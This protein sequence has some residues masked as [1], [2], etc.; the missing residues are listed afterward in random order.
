[1][2]VVLL[3]VALSVAVLDGTLAAIIAGVLLCAFLGLAFVLLYA[4][5]WA[6]TEQGVG[7]DTG[8]VSFV[9]KPKWWIRRRTMRVPWHEVVWISDGDGADDPS[10][11]P[12]TVSLY[13]HRTPPKEQAPTWL[14]HVAEGADDPELPAF[15][16]L[17]RVH[18]TLDQDEIK[19][20]VAAFRGHRPHL[21]GQGSPT[22][23]P[24][25]GGPANG[26]GAHPAPGAPGVPGQAPKNAPGTATV[27]Y[28]GS[29]TFDWVLRTVLSVTYFLMATGLGIYLGLDAAA[30][31]G[32]LV[33]PLVFLPLL[34]MAAGAFVMVQVSSA[35]RAL[36]PQGVHVDAYGISIYRNP[37]WWF[38]GERAHVGWQDVHHFDSRTVGSRRHAVLEISVHLHRTTREMRLPPWARLVMAGETKWRFTAPHHPVLLL[39]LRGGRKAE[40]LLK[41][42][43]M[44]RPDL[45]VERLEKQHAREKDARAHHHAQQARRQQGP[46]RQ[47]PGQQG[48]PGAQNR[49]WA[50]PAHAPT[51]WMNLRHETLRAWLMGAVPLA[52]LWCAWAYNLLEFTLS[53]SG[54][55]LGYVIGLGLAG[56]VFSIVSIRIMPNRLAH[57]GIS[58][59]GYG[60]TLVQGPFLWS[61]GSTAHLP[62]GQILLVREDTPRIAGSN[63]GR[64]RLSA[65][66]H[67][68][69][70]LTSVPHWCELEQREIGEPPATA[71]QPLTRVRLD[72]REPLQK[73]VT[74][75]VRAIRPDLIDNR[76]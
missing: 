76:T 61:S 27:D 60:I 20:L 49:P 66:M 74:E 35:P 47:G 7:V 65:F 58:V 71:H 13:L 53:G 2:A 72:I 75:A 54:E 38:N 1:M 28:G 68:P 18:V 37:K 29:Q 36:T 46:G 22:H 56:T 8:G 15:S 67:H 6:Y 11:V 57:Q 26:P 40:D 17:P 31:D 50:D 9:Q 24:G 25:P 45:S 64:H 63:A 41:I 34:I 4:L 30:S 62:W 14:G 44:A 70:L 52:F 69:D 48:F 3:L 43:R 55:A 10:L 39:R 42:L 23:I 16:P 21:V 32:G 33:L 59:D 19:Q 5:P 12:G 51:L 73:R